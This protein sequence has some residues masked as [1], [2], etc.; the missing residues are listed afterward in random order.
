MQVLIDGVD[1]QDRLVGRSYADAPEIDGNVIING[2]WDVEPGD[3]IEVNITGSD[4][5]DLFA[6]VI[7]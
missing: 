5:H 1:E 2:G 6:E 4:Q 3:F 7:E